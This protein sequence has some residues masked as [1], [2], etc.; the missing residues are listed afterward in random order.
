METW[1]KKNKHTHTHTCINENENLKKGNGGFLQL[2]WDNVSSSV[3]MIFRT[4]VTKRIN[5][6]V[7]AQGTYILLD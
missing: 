3:L 4:I 7:N 5:P 2:Y 6:Q 1:K